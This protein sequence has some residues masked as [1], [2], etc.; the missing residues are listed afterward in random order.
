MILPLVV[1]H[2]EWRAARRRLLAQE[3][4]ATRL[5][6][7]L[8]AQR[9]QLPRVKVVHPYVFQ[10][11][12]GPRT[13]GELFAGRRQLIVYHF[14]FAPDWDE[15]CKGCS[16]LAD[17]VDG[18]LV[19][20]AARDTAFVAISRAPLER[21]EPFRK[22]MGWRFPW[23]SSYGSS[24]NYDFHVTL[25]EDADAEYEHNFTSAALLLQARKIPSARGEMPGLSVFLCDRN[26]IYHT[27]STYQRGLDALLATYTLLDLTPLGRQ[28]TDAEPALSWLRHH[29][30]YGV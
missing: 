8:A 1:S 7:A 30:R 5:R 4:E 18:I 28:E 17:S 20:L 22:R 21:I 2:V 24:F 23:F 19:H 6:D 13:L 16:H 15:G 14:M 25:D 12:E 26:D 10:G 9:R 3:K 27:Y 29:D 11:R